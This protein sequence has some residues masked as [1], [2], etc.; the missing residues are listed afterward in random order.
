MGPVAGAGW[1]GL[2]A[3][4]A[5]GTPAAAAEGTPAAAIVG[6][7]AAA[8][9]WEMVGRVVL[10]IAGGVDA[11]QARVAAT[12]RERIAEKGQGG[13]SGGVD[14]GVEWGGLVALATVGIPTAAHGWGRV[15]RAVLAIAGEG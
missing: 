5:A 12:S 15:G 14:G 10:A 9:S 8:N 6:T 2:L 13:L 7:P 3:V 4:V 1:G 11:G